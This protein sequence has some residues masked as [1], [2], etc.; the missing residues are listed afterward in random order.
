MNPTSYNF[1]TQYFFVLSLFS[2]SQQSRFSR[3]L[4]FFREDV[5]IRHIDFQLVALGFA[6]GIAD[7]MSYKDFSVFTLNQTGNTV[8]FALLITGVPLTHFSSICASLFG[9]LVA[10][11]ISGQLSHRIG[12]HRRWWLILNSFFQTALIF[13]VVALLSTHVILTTGNNAYILVLLLAISYGCQVAMARL[14]S[15]PEIPTAMVTSPFIDLLIDSKLF[16]RHNSSR[17]RRLF[18]LIFFI[19]GV[20]VGS[21][22]YTRIN[23]QFILVIAGT[24]KSLVA[25][26]FFF[27]PK[28]RQ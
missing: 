20:I 4:S 25:L 7:V 21:F 6:T 13:I 3:V 17:N 2:V 22:S 24:V 18:Y 11:F 5:D 15:C 10:G 19:A 27:I 26:S 1:S 14:Q 12:D 23:S 28:A 8:V 9:F 16:K